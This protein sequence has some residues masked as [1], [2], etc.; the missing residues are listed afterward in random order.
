MADL[1]AL[2]EPFTMRFTKKNQIHPFE[3][4]SSLEFFSTKNDVSLIVFGNHSKKRP[5]C[6][7]LARCFDHR[8]LDM[9]EL[10]IDQDTFR[11]I[12]QFKAERKPA[13]GLK[14]LLAFSGTPFDS[15]TPNAYTLAKSIFTDMFKGQDASSID[16]EGL[17]YMI[18][19]TAGEEEEGLPAPRIHM[20]VYR[21]ITKR[22]GQKLP[23]VE[24][25]E[26]GP[27]LDFI[28]GRVKEADESIMRE[29]LKRPKQLEPRTKKNITTDIMGDKLGQIHVGKQDLGTL[30]TR[31]MK[32]LKRQLDV[33]DDDEADDGAPTKAVRVE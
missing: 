16:V 10:Y 8:L 29:A 19:F 20:R 27:R 4:A 23:R 12:Q 1:N 32:G 17:Q 15:P 5:H 25:E 26:M 3:D 11:S 24:T 2:K 14:P 30:Q 6:V 28:V 18:Q 9:I 33:P 21:I 13:I 7:T 22:S 31:K